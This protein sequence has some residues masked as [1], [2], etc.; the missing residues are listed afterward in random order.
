MQIFGSSFPKA[1]AYLLAP[2]LSKER[3]AHYP[4]LRKRAEYMVQFAQKTGIPVPPNYIDVFQA[5]DEPFRPE[6]FRYY[7]LKLA[8]AAVEMLS[9]QLMEA[10][11]EYCET[12]GLFPPMPKDCESIRNAF[13]GGFP[14][15]QPTSLAHV[16]VAGWDA[17]EDPTFLDET[18]KDLHSRRLVLLNE[19]MLKSIEVLELASLIEESNA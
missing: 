2:R 8:D 9:G 3:A 7:M 16:I 18:K 1:F 13:L 19:I 12:K 6:R 5:E 11:I 14:S 15:N 17:Y 10:A 4:S